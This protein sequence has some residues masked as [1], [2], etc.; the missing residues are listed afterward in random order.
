MRYAC[1]VWGLC[2]VGVYVA[3]VVCACGCMY[4]ACVCGVMSAPCVCGMCGVCTCALPP[5]LACAHEDSVLPG[6]QQPGPLG[7]PLSL[8][9][10]WE[11]GS[12]ALAPR[13]ETW[14]PGAGGSACA[15]RAAG[16]PLLRRRG[17]GWGLTGGSPL[18]KGAGCPALLLQQTGGCCRWP[19]FDR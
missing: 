5:G 16:A 3:C 4:V 1:P 19:L 15:G 9:Q 13:P 2:V 17:Q 6:L 14:T 11:A 12:P 8:E 7:P 10:Y 18:R